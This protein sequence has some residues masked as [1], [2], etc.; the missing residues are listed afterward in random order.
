MDIKFMNESVAS[1]AAAFYEVGNEIGKTMNEYIKGLQEG[2]PASK[3]ELIKQIVAMVNLAFSCE[4]FLKS[5]LDEEVRN[6]LRIHN[7][8]NL[9]NKQE[10]EFREVIKKNV[11][12]IRKNSVSDYDEIKFSNEL[13]HNSEIFFKWRYYYERNTLNMSLEF[14]RSFSGALFY[15]Y[16]TQLYLLSNNNI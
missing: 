5:R 16:E 1:E 14:I 9:F 11:I 13:K 2:E 3:R 6:G 4:L 15:L 7:L 12:K 10:I 8:E